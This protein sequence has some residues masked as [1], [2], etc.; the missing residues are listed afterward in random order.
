MVQFEKPK[1]DNVRRLR[2]TYFIDPQD[3]EFKEIIRNAREMENTN[4]SRYAMQDMQ[5]K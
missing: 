5:E 3:K 2:G 1:L 4:G